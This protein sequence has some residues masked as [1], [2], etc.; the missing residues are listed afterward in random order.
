MKTCAY[1]FFL[2]CILC[3]SCQKDEGNISI[4][5]DQTKYDVGFE[6]DVLSIPFLCNSD[7]TVMSDSTWCR[8]DPQSGSGNGTLSVTV[9]ANPSAQTRKSRVVIH[10]T[11]N[12]RTV[13]QEILITQTPE[14]IEHHY[15]LPVVFHILYNNASDEKQNIRGEWLTEI[16]E[17]C[18]LFYKNQLY[19]YDN[20]SQDMNLQFVL[21]TTKPDGTALEEP[22]IERIQWGQ[23]ITIS[24]D[25]F[26][27]SNNTEYVDL[28]WD[29]TSYINIFIYA[30]KEDGVAGISHLPYALPDS[31]LD[32]LKDGSF[33]LDNPVDYPHCISLNNMFVYET[34][35]NLDGRPELTTTFSHEMGHYLGL[36]HAFSANAC[37]DTDYCDDTPNYNRASYESW[38]D[39]MANRITFKDAVERTACDNTTFTSHNIMDYYHSYSDRFTL[40][41]RERVRH[42]LNNSP[43]IPGPKNPVDETKLT[44]S[45]VPPEIRTIR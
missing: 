20:Q 14:V 4:E 15:E 24:C 27:N 29:P 17:Q 11:N 9:D 33:Y 13:S 6:G 30:F 37:N 39:R 32:G 1:S 22:G 40:D 31:P 36:F 2:F 10:G 7:W 45:A 16:V 8:P 38:L 21:A 35:A 26:M 23:S 12:T 5:T 18:N 44:K 28:L 41:Q 34:N 3:L 43:L 25:E 19:E 42:V